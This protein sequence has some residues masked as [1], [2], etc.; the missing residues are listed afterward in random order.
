M[1]VETLR[2]KTDWGVTNDRGVYRIA[3]EGGIPTILLV[4]LPL[5]SR[6]G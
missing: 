4:C 5:R 3:M 1:K 6:S 2:W